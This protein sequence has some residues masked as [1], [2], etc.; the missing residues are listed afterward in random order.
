MSGTKETRY[1]RTQCR[2]CH[3]QCRHRRAP[4]GIVLNNPQTTTK[5]LGYAELDKPADTIAWRWATS[6]SRV[7]AAHGLRDL[8]ANLQL[9]PAIDL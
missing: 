8:N 7:R 9:G 1:A 3:Y 2:H 5:G 4:P 6:P